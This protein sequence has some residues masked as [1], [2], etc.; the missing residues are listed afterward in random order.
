MSHD[1]PTI[2]AE[3]VL[4]AYAVGMF[5]MAEDAEDPTLFWVEPKRR[6]IIPLDDFHISRR[7]ARTIRSDRFTIRTDTD[8]DGVIHGCAGPRPDNEKTWINSKIH[9]LYGE[10]FRMGRCHTV[11]VYA[12]N[13]LVG[14]LY[15]ISLGSAFFGESMFHTVTDAS[16][17]ALVHLVARL[18]A[19]GY[20]L[21]DT[22]FITDHLAQ[23][24]ATE[25]S[26]SQYL[27]L[28]D[29]ALETSSQWPEDEFNGETA[30][31]TVTAASD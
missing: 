19:S 10:L 24:G 1:K 29:K 16:K 15:G 5:P 17:V 6:G 21:L 18:K 2:T 8:F 26:R 4:R 30:L 13:H 11:E 22:Q 14:G 20:T 23:F 28:L 9:E 27:K 12:D 31:R 3:I 25:I 7:L